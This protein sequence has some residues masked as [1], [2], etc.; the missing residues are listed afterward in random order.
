MIA[1]LHLIMAAPPLVV[2]RMASA[3]LSKS[4]PCMQVFCNRGLS[5]A[6]SS[7]L[8]GPELPRPLPSLAT[9]TFD[10]QDPIGLSASLSDEEVAS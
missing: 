9:A 5:T 6:P 2:R 7:D 8:S 10:W 4:A 1:A 3:V